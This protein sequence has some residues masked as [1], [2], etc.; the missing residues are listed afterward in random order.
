MTI[1]L[2]PKAQNLDLI[3]PTACEILID[4]E[5]T[6]FAALDLNLDALLQP[7]GIVLQIYL[8]LIL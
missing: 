7:Y 6:L 1:L 2:L 8:S 5:Y 3:T 4:D